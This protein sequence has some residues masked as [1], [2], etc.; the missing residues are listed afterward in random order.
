MSSGDNI[1]LTDEETKIYKESKLDDIGKEI[2]IRKAIE[3]RLKF[4]Y[5]TGKCYVCKSFVNSDFKCLKGCD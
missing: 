2:F 4:S 5:Y 3:K 1:T